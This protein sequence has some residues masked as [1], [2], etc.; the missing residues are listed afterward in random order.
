M[1]DK[2]TAAEMELPPPCLECRSLHKQYTTIICLAHRID[3]HRRE[4]LRG[5]PL[6]GRLVSPWECDLRA[7][8]EE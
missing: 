2:Q 5:V 1:M 3:Y 4:L 7:E 6:V 8:V